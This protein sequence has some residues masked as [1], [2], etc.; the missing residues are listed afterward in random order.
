MMDGKAYPPKGQVWVC[1]AC[2]K[3]ARTRYGVDAAGAHTNLDHG[4]DESCV[5]HA[6]LCH[7]EKMDGL[8]VAVD[9]AEEN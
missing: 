8:F 3:R 5:M 4:W 6:V 2:G 1:S 7:E 9:F